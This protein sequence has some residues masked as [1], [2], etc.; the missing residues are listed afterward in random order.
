MDLPFLR[1]AVC[2]LSW[3]PHCILQVPFGFVSWYLVVRRNKKNRLVAC[4]CEETSEKDSI[5]RSDLVM[6]YQQIDCMF[7]DF[8]GVFVRV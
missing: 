3:L 1:C 7:L 5:I 8:T 2:R 6:L 4:I